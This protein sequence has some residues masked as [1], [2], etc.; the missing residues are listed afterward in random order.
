MQPLVKV[1]IR[2]EGRMNRNKKWQEIEIDH[3]KIDQ[4]GI[5]TGNGNDDEGKYEVNGTVDKSAAVKI[6]KKYVGFRFLP[7][8]QVFMLNLVEVRV[9]VRLLKLSLLPLF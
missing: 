7:N 5:M 3:M 2:W 4:D 9:C 1:M 8:K 6:N